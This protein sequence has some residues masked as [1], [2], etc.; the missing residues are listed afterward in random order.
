[1]SGWLGRIGLRRRPDAGNRILAIAR[2]VTDRRVSVQAA[3]AEIRQPQ[4]LDALSPSDFSGFAQIIDEQGGL[5]REYAIVLARLVSAAA[6]ARGLDREVVDAALHLDSLLPGDDPARERERLLHDAWSVA[7]RTG[8]REGA[9]EAL[10]RLGMR[11][12]ESGETE[13]AKQTLR[14]QLTTG[15]ETADSATEIAA[16]LAL[17]DRLRRE[18]QRQEAQ[19]L[20][21]RAGRAAQRMDDPHAIAEALARQIDL[22]PASTDLATLAA[23]QR[24]AAEAARRTSDLGLQSRLVLNLADTLERHGKIEEAAAQ[25]AQGLEIAER[26][27]DLALEVRCRV[28]LAGL[29][30]GRGRLAE[31]AGQER[32]LLAL[33]ERL[34]NRMAASDWASRLGTSLLEMGDLEGAIEAFDR[35]A[36]L[37]AAAGDLQ[38]EQRAAGGLGIALSWANRPAESLELLMRALAIA[39]KMGDGAGEARW[40]TSIGESLWRYGQLDEV[41]RPLREAL[42]AAQRIDDS[43]QQVELLLMLGRLHITRGQGPRAREALSRALEVQRRC[44]ESEA[45]EHYSGL[46]SLA[47]ETGQAALA[48]Q[49]FELALSAAMGGNDQGGAARIHLRLA[50]IGRKRGDVAFAVDHLRQ[51][52]RH[53][54]EAGD[55]GL[56]IQALQLEAATLRATGQAEAVEVFLETIRRCRAVEDHECEAAM[57]VDL[58]LCL[59]AFG[60]ES[61]AAEALREGIAQ[62]RE[63][64]GAGEELI[65]R[66]DA[67]LMALAEHRFGAL[68]QRPDLRQEVTAPDL[69]ADPSD[70]PQDRED[71]LFREA[72]LP[73]G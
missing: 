59:A 38:R 51:A 23:L 58:G 34:G 53:A 6:R 24:Q 49:L 39:Q 45:V 40:L 55:H 7:E 12:M 17:G 27:G 1:M 22:L 8:Y 65:E 47:Q 11:A 15:D 3:L 72:T 69:N 68:A 61:E 18:G 70:A 28:A 20:Y 41:D 52:S 13:R 42:A 66:A 31:A 50:M 48:T 10:H 16:A 57:A 33:E 67:A 62:A 44:P 2:D 25:L 35:A 30:L 64:G 9:R 60:R 4:V 56:E 29:E 32:G 21:R 63:L 19:G 73:P 54:A 43:R 37:G 5:D 36:S 26:I 46:A 14:Q 71:E